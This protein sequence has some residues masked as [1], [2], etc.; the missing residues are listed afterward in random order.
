MNEFLRLEVLDFDKCSAIIKM[1]FH[2]CSTLYTIYEIFVYFSSLLSKFFLE[3]KKAVAAEIELGR[4]TKISSSTFERRR[5]LSVVPTSVFVLLSDS[6]DFSF[7]NLIL[8][9]PQPRRLR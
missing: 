4:L 3:R 6:D 5:E 9:S 7:R 1:S 8:S 2:L